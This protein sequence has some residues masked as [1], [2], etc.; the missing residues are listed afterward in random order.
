[1][2]YAI[3]VVPIVFGVL[4]LLER[5]FPLRRRELPVLAHLALNVTISVLAF[6]GAALLVK[7]S[8][9]FAMGWA[10]EREVGLASPR[11]RGRRG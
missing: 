10:E 3:L 5:R 2:S 8:I 1:M 7:P 11:R 6:G 9:R 4:L